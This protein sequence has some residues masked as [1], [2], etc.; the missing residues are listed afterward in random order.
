VALRV[1]SGIEDGHNAG[2]QQTTDCPS[3][4]K[5]SLPVFPFLFWILAGE[6]DRLDGYESVDLG[7]ASL[8]HYSHCSATNLSYDLVSSETLPPTSFH[9][10]SQ[11]QIVAEHTCF[12]V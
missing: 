11:V 6:R 8:V 2:M 1:F 10:G 7:I 3:L 5:K 12:P 9:I 4:M